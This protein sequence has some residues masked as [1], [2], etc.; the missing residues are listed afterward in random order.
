MMCQ[1]QED[2]AYRRATPAESDP[3]FAA[4]RHHQS[5]KVVA[6]TSPTEIYYPNL[7]ST[8]TKP[9]QK[10]N[11]LPTHA[12]I[13]RAINSLIFTEYTKIAHFEG[14]AAGVIKEADVLPLNYSRSVFQ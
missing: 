2:P 7:L 1:I 3:S 5:K 12:K 6:A 14:K 13:A 4:R 10:S 9:A 11:I 8:G